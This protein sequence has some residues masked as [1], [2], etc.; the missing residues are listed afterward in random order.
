MGGISHTNTNQNKTGVTILTSDKEEFRTRNITREREK[1]HIIIKW[2][3][4]HKG[5]TILKVYV[6]NNIASKYIKQN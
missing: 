1:N 4:H 3:S 6:C 2:P 5:I